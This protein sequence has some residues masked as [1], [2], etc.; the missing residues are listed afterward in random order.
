MSQDITRIPL[1]ALVSNEKNMYELTNAAIHRA[2][3]ISITNTEDMSAVE[4]KIVSTAIN[5]IINEEVLYQKK[6][7]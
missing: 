3:Q 1:E 2:R 4:G 7:S 6:N 5:E